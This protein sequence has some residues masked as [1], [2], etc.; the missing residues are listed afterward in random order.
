MAIG[1][2]DRCR[3]TIVLPRGFT[4]SMAGCGMA[5]AIAAALVGTSLSSG[6]AATYQEPPQLQPLVGDGKLPP[7]A[8]RVP[9]A[10]EVVT[11]L[12]SVGAYGGTI[13][14]ALRGNA[15]HNAILRAVGAQGLTR[16]T[17]DMSAVVPNV[18][19]SF[20]ANEDASEYTF[21]LRRGMRWSDGQPFTAD[22]IL[23][24]VQ[25]LLPDRT[26]FQSPPAR[27]AVNG[28]V[29][30][31]EKIDDHT[32]KLKF[33]GPYPTFP[34]E[35]ATPLGQHPVLYAKHYCQQFHPKY[36]P[37]LDALIA[38]ARANDWATVMRQYCGDIEVPSRWAN[39]R[40][41]TLDPWVITE[42]YTGGATRVAMERNPFFWQ[43]DPEGKH[44]PYVDTLVFPVIADIEA[45]LL[46]AMGGQL[47]LQV[48]HLTEI[49]N[50]PVLVD[51]ATQGGYELLEMRSLDSNHVGLYFNQSVAN[52]ELR[53]L[54]TNRDFRAALSLAT[55]RDDINEIVFFGQGKPAQVG[56][57]PEHRL[58]N[59]QLR[60]QFVTRDL[61]EANRL[62]DG[63][64]LTQRD[65]QNYRV[66]PGAGGRISLGAI[67]SIANPWQVET[68]E[69]IR[70]HWAEAGIELV[71]RNSE[72]SLFYDRAQNNDYDISVD[73][74][75]GGL[76]PTQDPRALIAV[77]PLES[78][79]SIAWARWYESGGKAG[80]EPSA[81]M[82][83]RMELFDRWKVTPDQEEADA[84]FREILQLAAD[85][86]EVMGIIEPAPQLGIRN[87]KLA[88]VYDT[89]PFGWM[90][91]TPGPSL[92]QQY[93]YAR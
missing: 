17:M 42:P 53:K 34:E 47:D 26:F 72:R 75:P 90:Y 37:N 92:P 18:A 80:E 27:Y 8:E 23:F 79:Q 45:I 41:P 71:I 73:N 36:A 9:E 22:D 21:K 54:I 56:P 89:M 57:L 11:P 51:N 38:E 88:N 68:L 91:G 83:K 19:E 74:V 50:K 29:M 13:R 30:Q 86:F 76:N 16:W 40:R 14:Q 20:T 39:P 81:S 43:V 5:A 64:G 49:S 32:V 82:K 93:Y 63:L 2:F 24:F 62:L 67:V 12:Q 1:L 44:L 69:L 52:L 25:D 65:P 87:A 7:V 3:E 33:A 28:Q 59:E 61:T 6:L 48:R 58:Y 78:R 66:Y 55:N 70:N 85:E 35:L 31:A 10:P 15:D 60:T 4:R 46:S 84:L 77:H